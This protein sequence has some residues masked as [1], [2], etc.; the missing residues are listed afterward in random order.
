MRCE[1][2]VG[3]RC[4]PPIEKEEGTMERKEAQVRWQSIDVRS[5]ALPLYSHT[6]YISIS[7]RH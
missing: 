4:C 1:V 6:L 7:S 5:V 3:V 2:E